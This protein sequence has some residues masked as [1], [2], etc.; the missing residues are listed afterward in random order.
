MIGLVVVAGHD[1]D[2]LG[3]RFEPGGELRRVVVPQVVLR[4]VAQ[5]REGEFGIGAGDGL[6]ETPAPLVRPDD[7]PCAVESEVAESLFDEIFGAHLPGEHVGAR[8]VGDGAEAALEV[9]RHDDDAVFAEE[10][11]VVAVVELADDRVCLHLHGPFDDRLGARLVADGE[12]QPDQAPSLPHLLSITR[13]ADQQ[14]AG[15]RLGEVRQKNH[16]CH[17]ACSCCVKD[18]LFIGKSIVL[19][20]RKSSFQGIFISDDDTLRDVRVDKRISHPSA[21]GVNIVL[22]N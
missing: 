4:L 2:R 17:V 19:L 11:D 16:S 7:A 21:C 14:I 22:S 3:Q 5:G 1:G 12:R 13:Y 9:L 20:C 10:L 18:R 8:D 6:A 15:V